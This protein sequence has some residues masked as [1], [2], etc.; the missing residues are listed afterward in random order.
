MTFLIRKTGAKAKAHIWNGND[1]ACR[2]WSTGGLKKSRY[3]ERVDPGAHEICSM[4]QGVTLMTELY[5]DYGGEA[6]NNDRPPG[7]SCHP[8]DRVHYGIKVCPRQHATTHCRIASL[9]TRVSDLM[10][11][12][13]KVHNWLVCHPI[14]SAADMAQSFP[15]MEE[16]V[17]NARRG[18]H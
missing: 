3:E 5:G 7:C 10:A 11:A 17:R 18:E 8:D 15:T 16:I 12:L 13:E 4:C 9:E 14:A 2:M 1:T 6:K